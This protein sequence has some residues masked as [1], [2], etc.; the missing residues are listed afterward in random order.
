MTVAIY[1]LIFLAIFHSVYESILAP[2]WRLDLRFRLFELRGE[3][4][5]LELEFHGSLNSHYFEYL[6]DSINALISELYRFDAAAIAFAEQESR[7][8]PQFRKGAEERSRILD[9]CDIPEFT[10]IRQRSL[11]IAARA[12]LV[13]SGAGGPWTR[14]VFDT[15]A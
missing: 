4:R 11:E 6:Q 10:A 7:R 8:D 12:L 2:S 3:V 13:N 14:R 5:S 15:E 9:D 1:I